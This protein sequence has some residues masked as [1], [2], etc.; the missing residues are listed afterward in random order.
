MDVTTPQYIADL[1]AWGAIGARTDRE[2]DPPR[3]GLGPVVPGWLQERHQ[4]RR[5][6]WRST[7]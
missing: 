3:D 2:P 6:A 4:R 5:E 7:R 1:V